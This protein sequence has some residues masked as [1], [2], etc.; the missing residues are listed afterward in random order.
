M[1]VL[2]DVRKRF[3]SI[4]AVDGLSLE[5]RRGEMLGLL[6]PNGAG[7]TTSIHM[8]V[9]LLS[10]DSG[11]ITI[12][13]QPGMPGGS[14]LDPAVRRLIGVAPQ[15]LA[16]YEGLSGEENLLFF[17]R[18][19]GL[20]GTLLRE[21]VET[22]LS[23]VGL[24]DRRMHDCAGYSGGMKRRLNLAAALL[25]DPHLLF[26]DEPTVGVDPQ[27]RNALFDVL[28]NLRDAGK[29]IVYSTHYMEEAQ[30]MCDRVAI[31]DGGR[32]LALDTVPAL[33]KQF[34]GDSTVT[35][36]R[37]SGEESIRTADPVATLAAAIGAGAVASAQIHGPDLES[38]FLRLTGRSLR[39]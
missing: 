33:L 31:I 1:L 20:R 24:T 12:E 38:A 23:L 14:P 8:S 7:K 25:H 29:T 9:G 36:L 22:C 5:V 27:S 35:L 37:D 15:S 28:A 21:R 19:Y 30:R 18:L 34:G 11:S 32:L 16:I 13:G 17:G 39:D 2:R 6:G 4:Q 10:P 3:G 26:L